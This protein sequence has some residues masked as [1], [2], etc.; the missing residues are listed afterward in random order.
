MFSNLVRDVCCEVYSI[1]MS[2]ISLH[3]HGMD[4]ILS[5]DGLRAFFAIVILG[6]GTVYL[7]KEICTSYTFSSDVLAYLHLLLFFLVD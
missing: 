4:F 1:Y 2:F 5:G 3:L 6:L 7:P